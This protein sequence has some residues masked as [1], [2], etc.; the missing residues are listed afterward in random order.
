MKG[1]IFD[2]VLFFKVFLINLSNFNFVLLNGKIFEGKSKFVNKDVFI[3][4]DRLF[5]FEFLDYLRNFFFKKILIKFFYKVCI[6]D[7]FLE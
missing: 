1:L 2:C 7:L 6:Y 5:R 3:I 4:I